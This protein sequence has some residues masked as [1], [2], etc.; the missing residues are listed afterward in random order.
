[1]GILGM[2][3]KKNRTICIPSDGNYNIGG[4]YKYRL[5]GG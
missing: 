2:G 1:M 3:A 4:I 5:M